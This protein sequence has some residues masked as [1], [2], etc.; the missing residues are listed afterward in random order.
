MPEF[1]RH[2][3]IRDVV[4]ALGEAGGE[5]LYRHGYDLGQGFVDQLSQY[6]S[7]LDAERGGRL[8]DLD[9][10]IAELNSPPAAR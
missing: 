5:I 8:R 10:L 6:Q 4:A 3:R 7:L 9:G 2:T 1:S